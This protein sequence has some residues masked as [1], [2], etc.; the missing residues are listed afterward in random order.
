MTRRETAA[1]GRPVTR[2]LFAIGATAPWGPKAE[3]LNGSTP[4]AGQNVI[5]SA[6]AD[7]TPSTVT[8]T[9][10]LAGVASAEFNIGPLAEGADVPLYA[11]LPGNTT[12]AT[13]QIY[14]VHPEVAQLAAVSGAGQTISAS[15]TPAP[16]I[17]KVTDAVG[18]PM[19]G[20][21]VIFYETLKQWTPD[22]P[23]QGRCPSAPTVATQ[24]VQATS[25]ADGLVTLTPLIGNGEPTRLYVTAVTGNVASLNFEIEQQP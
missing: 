7:A 13:F 9:T 15:A 4:Q 16:V 8:T 1:R 22:C 14:S 2:T 11:C 19:A 12:C 23:A 24:T 21:T 18:H 3:A 20:G 5:W 10:N 25:G 6:S 17:L